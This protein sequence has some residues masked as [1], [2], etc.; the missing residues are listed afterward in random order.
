MSPRQPI[1]FS[2]LD[3][4]HMK[5]GGLLNKHICEKKKKNS[6]ISNETVEF[7]N[8]HFSENKSV[9]AISRHSNQSSYPIE[10]HTQLFVPH[11]Y[12]CYMCDTKRIG[13]TASEEKSFEMLMTDGRRIPVYTISLPISLRLR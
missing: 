7:V 3:K 2:D 5:S 12:R 6:N 8:F 1:K 13:F 11:T 10:K 9:A 4:S